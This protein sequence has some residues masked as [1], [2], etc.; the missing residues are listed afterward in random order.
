MWGFA[1]L[2]DLRGASFVTCTPQKGKGVAIGHN[3]ARAFSKPRRR[4]ALA[5]RTRPNF[6]MLPPIFHQVDFARVK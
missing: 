4:A 2:V 6:D 3:V 1:H 5:H